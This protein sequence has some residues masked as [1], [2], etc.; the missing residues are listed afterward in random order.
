MSKSFSQILLV[1]IGVL[2]SLSIALSLYAH[3]VPIFPRDLYLTLLLQSFNNKPLTL[4]MMWT[5]W[6]FGD[7]RAALLVIGAGLLVWWKLGRFA[8]IMILIAGLI[9]FLNEGF[10]DAVNRPRPSPEEVQIIGINHGSG[11][12]SGHTFLA[13]IFLGMLAFLLFTRLKNRLLRILSLVVLIPLAL[14]VGTSRIYLG[15][16]WPSDVYGGYVIGAL[17][18]TLLIWGYEWWRRRDRTRSQKPITKK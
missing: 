11:Y 14:L 2:A 7:W 10:K 4:V 8:S 1:I 13:T 12:P 17:F 3:W 6:A 16:H 18:L 15:A 5:S 9:S